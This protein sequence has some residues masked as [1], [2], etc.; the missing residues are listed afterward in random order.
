VPV[1]CH[2][3]TRPSQ[4]SGFRLNDLG[5]RSPIVDTSTLANRRV[6]DLEAKVTEM[7]SDV[8]ITLYR[9]DRQVAHRKPQLNIWARGNPN[10][11]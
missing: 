10:S 2:F 1:P 4:P 8:E 5:F 6:A 7:Q 9:P 3:S 11:D